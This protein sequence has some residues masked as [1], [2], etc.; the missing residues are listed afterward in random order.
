MC[1]QIAVNWGSRDSGRTLPLLPPLAFPQAGCKQFMTGKTKSRW[2]WR[3][4]MAI[5]YLGTAAPA[6]TQA[7]SG[8]AADAGGAAGCGGRGGGGGR[9]RRPGRCG[10]LRGCGGCGASGGGGGGGAPGAVRDA[11]RATGDRGGGLRSGCRR[12]VRRCDEFRGP[13]LEWRRSLGFF[14]FFPPSVGPQTFVVTQEPLICPPRACFSSN[15]SRRK[16]TQRTVGS[17]LIA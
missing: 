4:R 17:Q 15:E 2:R 9:R 11:G 10:A 13:G 16:V 7:G 3:K 12:R 5:V 14:G 6:V 1:S 8:G